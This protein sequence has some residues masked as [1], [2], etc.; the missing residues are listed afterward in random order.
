MAPWSQR[1]SSRDDAAI[2][3]MPPTSTGWIGPLPTAW[4]TRPAP[5]STNK[6]DSEPTMRMRLNTK[7]AVLAVCIA[8]ASRIGYIGE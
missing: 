7:P 5:S 4:N 3:T 6:Y 1:G 2:N 8:A